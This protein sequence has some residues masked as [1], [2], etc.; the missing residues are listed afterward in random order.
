M[1]VIGELS[2]FSS[3]RIRKLILLC[4]CRKANNNVNNN[5][6]SF[7][8]HRSAN[9]SITYVNI[10]YKVYKLDLKKTIHFSTVKKN[11]LN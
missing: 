8:R 1:G 6:T 3:N 7:A 10:S 5:N 2:L 4:V 9:V 11:I